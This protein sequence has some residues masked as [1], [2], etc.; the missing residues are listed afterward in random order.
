MD[1]HSILPKSFGIENYIPSLI[2]YYPTIIPLL[3]GYSHHLMIPDIIPYYLIMFP[4]YSHD[5]PMTSSILIIPLSSHYYPIYYPTIIGIFPSLFP[6]SSHVS[7][8]VSHLDPVDIRS[9][10]SSAASLGSR[11]RWRDRRAPQRRPRSPPCAAWRRMFR[12]KSGT[13]NWWRKSG[14]NTWDFLY[15]MGSNMKF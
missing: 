14:I 12:R 4:W 6:W 7:Q 15:N 13:N 11:H 5:L 8:G 3:L 1:V 9:R 10:R 2:P